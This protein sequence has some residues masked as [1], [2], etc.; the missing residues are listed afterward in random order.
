M[1]R[2]VSFGSAPCV[3][4]Q[5][6]LEV[7]AAL[8]QPVHD[9]VLRRY[10]RCP[11]RA[12]DAAELGERGRAVAGVVNGQRADDEVEDAIGVGQ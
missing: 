7:G 8:A 2:L 3:G 4:F 11:A 9:R 1:H 10:H 12:Q 5:G 6:G